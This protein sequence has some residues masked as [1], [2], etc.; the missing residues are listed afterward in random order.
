MMAVQNIAL[1]AVSLGL[2]THI[3]TGAVMSDPAAHAAV[4]LPAGQRI[5]AIVNVG[6]PAEDVPAKKRD[7][8][9][10]FTTWVP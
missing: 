5:V 6:T 9:S 8:A 1:T 7:P 4:G 10:A 2:G 3:K